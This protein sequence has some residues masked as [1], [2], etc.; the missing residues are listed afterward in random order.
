[1]NDYYR[2]FYYWATQGL[3]KNPNSPN[4]NYTEDYMLK[5]Q[6]VPPV[7]PSCPSCPSSGVCTNC[8]GQGGCGTQTNNG[9]SYVGNVVSTGQNAVSSTNN[10]VSNTN[11]KSPGFLLQTQDNIGDV[12]KGGVNEVKTGVSGAVG[13][14]K[15][16]VGGTV[17]LGK[18]IVGDTVELGKEIVG[19]TVKLGKDVVKGTVGLGKDIV[20]GIANLGKDPNQYQRNVS[21]QDRTGYS[22]SYGGLAANQLLP[23]NTSSI[24]DRSSL[25]GAMPNKGNSNYMPLGSDFSKFGR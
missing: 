3:D 18:E 6:I 20:G 16:I 5:T 23:Q 15:E 8:G 24:V 12:L 7:C 4:F 9:T 25:Y 17:G 1:M 11:N 21:G 13:L 19:G 2:W 10:A 14:G 22:N